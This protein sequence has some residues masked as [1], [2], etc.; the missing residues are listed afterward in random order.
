MKVACIC[1]MNNNFFA[2]VRH[3]RDRGIDA[4]LLLTN[5]EHPH[6]LP[7]A[8]T[9]DL[10]FQAYTRHLPWGDLPSWRT[11]NPNAIAEQLA[12]YDF[13]IGT[14]AVPAFVGLAGR[15][16]D[17]FNPHGSDLYQHPFERLHLCRH[18]L[19]YARFARAQARG[20]RNSRAVFLGSNQDLAPSLDKLRYKGKV[21]YRS[22]PFIHT[23]TYNHEALEQHADRTH[24]HHEFRRIRKEHDIMVMHQTRHI[25]STYVDAISSKRN[26]VA[27]EG[28][29]A[30]VHATKGRRNPGLVL[31][32]YGPDVQAS[33]RLIQRLGI[34]R[35]V[36]WLPM[37]YRKDLMVGLDMADIS[38]AQFGLSIVHNGV[39][40]EALAL[41]KPVMLRRDDALY[42][43]I[44]PSLYEAMNAQNSEE[45]AALFLDYERNPGRYEEMGRKGREWF[46]RHAVEEPL[47]E[48]MT[49]MGR[50]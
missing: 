32:E 9:Y 7:Q 14:H 21:V 12:P 2:L 36:H 40:A 39:I 5:T 28:F 18:P 35:N 23:P 25:W 8:D 46:L 27:I 22:V 30:L 3:L 37:M 33:R 48:L 49:L 13:L 43:S 29:A 6:F 34:E 4:E 24:W 17:V 41:G 31:C 16:L 38:V 47:G 42:G 15:R 26:D 1:N 10:G 50:T 45:A 11:I 19:D 20:I 44:L